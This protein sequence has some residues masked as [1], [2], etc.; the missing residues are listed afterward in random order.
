LQTIPEVHVSGSKITLRV[1]TRLA[2]DQRVQVHVV[3]FGESGIRLIWREKSIYLRRGRDIYRSAGVREHESVI[4]DHDRDERL[5]R[6]PKRLDNGIQHFLAVSAVKLNPAGIPLSYGVLLIVQDGPGGSHASVYACHHNG[7]TAPCRPVQHLMHIQET[8]GAS[9][10]EYLAPTCD[11]ATTEAIAEC[12]FPR[13]D[14][15]P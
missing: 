2:E 14:T 1:Q 11:A 3:P 13:S 8:I 7:H 6:D 12:H 9:G 15:R 5:F 4:A 10:G